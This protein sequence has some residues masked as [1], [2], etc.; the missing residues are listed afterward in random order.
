MDSILNPIP[1]PFIELFIQQ[2]QEGTY[3][4][5]IDK[6]NDR[7]F[8][9]RKYA[10]VRYENDIYVSLADDNIDEPNKSPNWILYT[11]FLRR[12]IND[13]DEIQLITQEN[14]KG[15]DV[16]SISKKGI[17]SLANTSVMSRSQ[18]WF[19]MTNPNISNDSNIV[20]NLQASSVSQ[21]GA[22]HVDAFVGNGFCDI[23]VTNKSGIDLSDR[24]KVVYKVINEY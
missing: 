22:W 21:K 6:K 17:I 13:K 11:D 8:Q 10:I 12:F 2:L 15:N 7:V 23:V 18:T 20:V 1:K 19:R 4:E 16:S 9:Y 24:L 5:W 14:S 3:L